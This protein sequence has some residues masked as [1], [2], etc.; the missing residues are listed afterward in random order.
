MPTYI[1]DLEAQY[2]TWKQAVNTKGL[3]VKINRTK[4]MVSH[5]EVKLVNANVAFVCS[6]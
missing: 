1:Q 4:I 3:R 6:V 5:M 2:T